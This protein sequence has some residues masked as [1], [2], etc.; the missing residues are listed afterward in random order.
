MR[1]PCGGH[2]KCSPHD[3]DDDD[4]VVVATLCVRSAWFL[5]CRL[6]AASAWHDHTRV[7]AGGCQI[8]ERRSPRSVMFAWF[9]HRFCRP[10]SSSSSLTSS[11]LSFGRPNIGYIFAAAADVLA[12]EQRFINNSSGVVV[13]FM[14]ATESPNTP[15]VRHHTG[16]HF[17][18]SICYGGDGG[19]TRN[20]SRSRSTKNIDLFPSPP[21]LFSLSFSNRFKY[22]IERRRRR[23]FTH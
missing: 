23:K 1:S 3:D 12:T 13:F 20:K 15:C 8:R 17:M 7:T 11:S 21:W 2:F 14:V 4:G 6:I 18:Y 9:L 5:L 10:S 16:R 19:C 22:I